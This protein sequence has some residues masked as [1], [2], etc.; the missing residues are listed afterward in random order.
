MYNCEY[1]TMQLCDKEQTINGLFW[2]ILHLIYSHSENVF[3]NFPLML[4]LKREIWVHAFNV[5]G[6]RKF[7]IVV[8][9]VVE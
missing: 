3:L 8:V 4:P 1:S 5:V 2:H 6:N 9:A 7:P